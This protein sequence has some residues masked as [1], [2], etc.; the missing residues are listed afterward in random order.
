VAQTDGTASESSGVRRWLGAD[1]RPVVLVAVVV[2]L[3]GLGGALLALAVAGEDDHEASC[4]AVAIARDVLPSV[5]TVAVTTSEGAG[6]NGTGAVFRDGGYILTNEHVISAAVNG[7]ATVTV[8][9]SDGETSEATVTG[10]DFATDLAVLQAADGAE[11]RPLLAANDSDAAL[12]GEPVFALG[13]PLGLSNTVT[14]GIVSA[15]G[16]YVPVPSRPGGAAHHLLDAIETDAAINPGNSGGPLV[17]CSGDQIG[18]NS[19]IST[20]PNAQGVGGGGSVGLGFAIPMS[21]AVPIADQLV[22]TGRAEHPIFGMAAV[23]VPDESGQVPQG[24]K[25]TALETDGPAAQ[26]GLEVGDV[27]VEIDGDAAQSTE[28]LVLVSLRHAAGDAIP[29]TYQRAGQESSAE[30]VLGPP[31]PAP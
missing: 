7:D 8:H 22:E 3:A 25:V 5:V 19:A 30:I 23:T 24:I 18:V 31:P 10:S 4:S 12:V 11:D 21:V 20:V 17:N 29:V 14:S 16:R 6:G 2:A 9:Y 1:W 15:L 13:A 26:A 27:I 28:Q